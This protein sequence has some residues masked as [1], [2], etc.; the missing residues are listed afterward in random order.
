MKTIFKQIMLVV[1]MVVS[2]LFYKGI[3]VSAETIDY[4]IAHSFTIT[5]DIEVDNA[6][7]LIK[8]YILYKNNK[9]CNEDFNFEAKQDKDGFYKFQGTYPNMV[10]F[11]FI[12]KPKVVPRTNASYVFAATDYFQNVSIFINNKDQGVSVSDCLKEAWRSNFVLV[13]DFTGAI[14]TNIGEPL[15]LLSTKGFINGKDTTVNYYAVE[16]KGDINI[17][18]DPNPEVKPP[19]DDNIPSNP[20]GNNDSNIDQEGN[21]NN[22]N[23]NTN[24]P[25]IT[26]LPNNTNNS[27]VNPITVALIIIGS[28]VGIIIFIELYKLI[29]VLILWLRE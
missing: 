27:N 12:A 20:G 6:F 29:K 7:K 28:I 13:P 5:S 24:P 10:R 4:K 26:P 17:P 14:S 2:V 3:N 25:N 21:N 19:T 22:N 18:E 15:K 16:D 8:P 23:N 9:P 1:V 11:S